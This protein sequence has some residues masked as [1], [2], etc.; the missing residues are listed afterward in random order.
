MRLARR[1]LLPLPGL[2]C[3]CYRGAAAALRTVDLRSDTLSC[4]TP[5][6]RAAAAR[7]PLGDDVY[8]ED[9]TVNELQRQAAGLFGMEAS[10]FVPSGTMGNLI[11]VMCHCR[12][13]GAELIVGDQ[14]HIHLF[15]QGGTA[16]I[17]GVHSRTL[18]NLPD[19]TFDLNEL[20]S[21]IHNDY[22][23]PHCTRTRLICLENTHNV[24]GGRVLPLSFLQEVRSLA[25]KY[26]LAVHMDGARLMNAAVAMGVEAQAILRF[27]DSVS[28]CLSKGLG[29]PVGSL[30]G[31]RQSFIDQASHARKVLGG[32]MRQAGLLAAAGLISISQMVERLKDDHTN[33]RIFSQGIQKY[34]YPVCDTNM[35]ALETNILMLTVNDPRISPQEFCDRMAEVTAE[36]VAAVGCGVRVLMMPFYGRSVRA[37]WYLGISEEDTDLAVQKLRFVVEK[38]KG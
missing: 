9:P 34:A 21:K 7:A 38:L 36:E 22:T 1:L 29:A 2:W 16:Q 15:E 3:R 30:I 20:E 27:C 32:G 4:P 25:D 28:M 33:A 35:D 26:S 19:G 6:M 18:R 10:L 31:G 12:E 23:D 14:A 17:A 24:Q 11:S 13:R 37:V 8:G 5:D